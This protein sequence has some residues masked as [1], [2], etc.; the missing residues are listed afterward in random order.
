MLQACWLLDTQE[1]HW[2][3]IMLCSHRYSCVLLFSSPN[4]PFVLIFC[5]ALPYFVPSCVVFSLLHGQRVARIPRNLMSHFGSTRI[6]HHPLIPGGEIFSIIHFYPFLEPSFRW[7]FTRGPNWKRSL[8][9]SSPKL[10][11]TLHSWKFCRSR[12]FL[13]PPKGRERARLLWRSFPSPCTLGVNDTSGLFAKVGA[14]IARAWNNNRDR[15]WHVPS[16][17]GGGKRPD[18]V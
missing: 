8:K 12:D 7:A 15:K 2:L 13:Y 3:I 4:S 5:L 18:S 11:L 1:R 9:P 17:K 16:L 10:P 14:T 6:T